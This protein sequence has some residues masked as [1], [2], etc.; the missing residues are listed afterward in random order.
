MSNYS[1]HSWMLFACTRLDH[2][3]NQHHLKALSIS[4]KVLALSS[5][6]VQALRVTFRRG[7]TDCAP[8]VAI[9]PPSLLLLCSATSS[10]PHSTGLPTSHGRPR[11]PAGQRTLSSPTG[12]RHARKDVAHP[13]S[14]ARPGADLPCFLPMRQHPRHDRQAVRQS[15]HKGMCQLLLG[16]GKCRECFSG[17][18]DADRS[19]AV[20]QQGMPGAPLEAAQA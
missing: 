18:S 1:S 7:F 17:A 15:R 12:L 9:L 13:A 3:L 10:Q 19:A 2:L 20:L 16:P 6:T 14:V 5:A 8:L 4:G 11:H